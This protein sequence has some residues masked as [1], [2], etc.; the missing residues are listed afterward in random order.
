MPTFCGRQRGGPCGRDCPD[1]TAFRSK[2]NVLIMFFAT[3][4]T[5]SFAR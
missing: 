1:L 3:G 4:P 5:I 2:K